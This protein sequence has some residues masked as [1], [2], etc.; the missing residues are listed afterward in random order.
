[1]LYLTEEEV[2][3]LLPMAQAIEVVESAI[4]ASA[5]GQAVSTPRSRVRFP[6]GCLHVMAGGMVEPKA[7]LGLKAYTTFREGTRFHFLLWSAEDGRLLVLMQADRL[8]Q[9]RTGAA[10]G[11]SI[12]YLAR[13]E[14]RS[15]G[16]IGSGWQARS[17][18]EAARVVLP[19]QEIYVY[20]RSLQRREAFAREMSEGLGV[21]VKAL[22]S[23]REVVERSDIIITATTSSE[24]VLE[25]QWLKPGQHLVAMGSNSLARRELE[26]D[27]FQR[28]DLIF[29]DNKDQA[30]R[31][32][33]DLLIPVE[34]GIL[35]WEQV[36]DFSTVVAGLHP[37]RT[38]A[39]QITLFKSHGVAL[40]DVAVGAYVYERAIQQGVGK[41]LPVE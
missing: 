6:K 18:V 11:V 17:Q 7:Y 35:R 30:Q 34:R 38:S 41:E 12:R 39:E 1:M 25:G 10:T 5:F 24:P 19:L 14:A 23:A 9:I 40:W 37:G 29:V 33:G 15:L 28:V 32:S 16:I 36:Y 26:I 2:A 21:P 8:G 22:S 31:E 27:V 20:S 3:H 13:K 4:K